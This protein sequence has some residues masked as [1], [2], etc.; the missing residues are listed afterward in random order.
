MIRGYRV[1]GAGSVPRARWRQGKFMTH[2]RARRRSAVT[3]GTTLLAVTGLAL[4]GA[5]PASAGQ[6]R[7][8][9]DTGKLRPAAQ[10]PQPD[11]PTLSA[12]VSAQVKA[13]VKAAGKD[14]R[15]AVVVKLKDDSLASYDG[16]VAG[17]PATNPR[18]T[19]ARKLDPSSANSAKYLRYLDGRLSA[20]ES[21]TKGRSPDAKVTRR[22]DVVVGGVALVLPAEDVAKVAADPA[23][24][25]VFVDRLEQPQ[26]EV[27]PQFIGAPAAWAQAGG[28][29]NAGEGAIVGVLDTGIW[30]EHPSLSDPDP[31]G[32]AYTAPRPTTNGVARKCQF[33]G[34]TAGDA[35]FTC[36]NKLIGAYRFMSTYAAVVG[37]EP[38][39]FTT[40]RD[41]D[42]HGT[43]TATTA[44]GNAGVAAS[45]FGVPRGVVSGIAPRAHVIAYKVCGAAGCFSSDSAAAVKQAILDDVDAINFSISGGSNPYN[46]AVSL[47]FLD[48]YNAGVFVAA[49]AGNSGPGADTTDHREPWVTTVAASTGPRA[50]VGSTTL[51]SSD[52]ATTTESGTTLTA[53]LSTPAPVVSAASVGDPFCINGT[54]DGAFAGKV[55]VCQRGGGPG[56]VQ[57]G[58]NVLQRGAVGMILFNQSAAVTDL[59]T[60]NHFLPTVHVQFAQ[61]QALLA[62]L[63]AHPGVT[64]TITDG[65]AAPAQGDVMASFS[66]RG[67]AGQSLG[68]SKPDITA[69]GVQILAGHTPL[70]VDLATGPQGE[71]F[72]AIAGTSM[73]SPHVAGAGT[74]LASLHPDWT[75]GQIHSAIMTTA[76][77]AV[78]KEDGV[79]PTDAFDDGSGRVDLAAARNPLFTIDETGA[80]YVAAKDRLYAANYPSLY[81]PALSGSLTVN[82]TL[83]SVTGSSREYKVSV[84]AP[85]DLRVRVSST[86]FTLRPGASRTLAITVDGRDVPLGETRFATVTFRS[87]TRT[88][89][90]PVTVVRRQGPVE[91]TKTCAPGT[92]AKDATTTCTVTMTNQSATDAAVTLRDDVPSNLRVTPGSVVGGTSVRNR[93]TATTTIPAKLPPHV[94]VAQVDPA[95]TPAGG[96]LPLSLFGIAPIPGTSD[97][98]ISNFTVP[99]FTVAGVSYTRIGLVSNGY[100][101]LGGGT[102]ADV[103]F[104]NTA[105]PNRA[106]PNNIVAPFW[107]DLDLSKGGALRIGLIGDGV[108]TWVV[109]EF[110]AAPEFS[111]TGLV[112]SFQVWIALGGT[113]DV[114]VAYGDTVPGAV[115]DGGF[116]TVGV[117]NPDGTNGQTLYLDGVGTLPA[118]GDTLRVTGTPGETFSATVSF[119][120]TG[121]N[122]GPYVNYAE[123]TGPFDGTAIARF[124]GAVTR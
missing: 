3:I 96:Y 62:F 66:S 87:G 108:S 22:L 61:G 76:K 69:P 28:Q 75:P 65:A 79:T 2:G 101:V 21:R 14:G 123:V 104:V 91:V 11:G 105:L 72:Q 98:T 33:G 103:Q 27:T 89:T 29:E 41:D 38:G 112:H 82:R 99:A 56:R 39:E 81:V 86:E 74:M 84:S 60:D 16:G 26:T 70:S 85:R 7:A 23:V 106:R 46:D 34:P 5:G 95:T 51:T 25:A 77:T 59:E 48:A 116:A 57:K 8:A 36:N 64:A 47:A 119:S 124:A 45:I 32:K 44:A 58:F 92:V 52:G 73:S 110:E 100:V 31:S 24:E 19:G 80:N 42:G 94:A 4:S 68:V 49:S 54:A 1:R 71:L 10:Q 55:V 114:T 43:H 93:V 118:T 53:A 67:G 18:V 6:T 50:F 9:A 122:V 63:A 20:F 113:E 12:E 107:T 40:A 78:V 15:T 30:P 35:P 83:K 102:Q 115:G 117:E 109:A 120:A 13:A 37:L 111:N 97:E 17:L 88:F 121:K 90:F